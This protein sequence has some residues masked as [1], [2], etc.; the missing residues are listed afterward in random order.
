MGKKTAKFRWNN[1]WEVILQKSVPR[2]GFC[3]DYILLDLE[4][5]PGASDGARSIDLQ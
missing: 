2:P 5:V 1:L 4:K 3:W